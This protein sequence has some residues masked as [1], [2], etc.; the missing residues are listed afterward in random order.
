M[1]MASNYIF[2]SALPWD[3]GPGLSYCSHPR[4]NYTHTYYY[5]CPR[6]W[7]DCS[8]RSNSSYWCSPYLCLY[9]CCWYSWDYSSLLF[10][11]ILASWCSYYHS[12]WYSAAGSALC[13][14]RLT[15][16]A[17]F[18]WTG[19]ISGLSRVSSRLRSLIWAGDR[20]GNASS[21]LLWLF[22]TVLCGF[23]GYLKA[24]LSRIILLCSINLLGVGWR[25]ADSLG[26]PAT[27]T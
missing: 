22:A 23:T 12:R 14:P 16:L 25:K 5:F 2:F 8:R 17:L 10:C 19:W 18:L 27:S 9:R 13:W 26:W 7:A 1:A 6:F 15:G 20:S 4:C 21:C 11:P 3:P 24:S